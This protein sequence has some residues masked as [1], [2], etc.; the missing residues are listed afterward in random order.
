MIATLLAALALSA[1]PTS[2]PATCATVEMC[3]CENVTLPYVQ[4]C[5]PTSSHPAGFVRISS[6]SEWTRLWA[7]HTATPDKP[8]ALTRHAAPKIDF[9]QCIV[10]AY[11][12]GPSTNRDGEVLSSIITTPDSTTL[13]FEP[14]TFQTSGGLNSDDGGAV[15]TTPFGIWVIPATANPI[16]IEEARRTLK[17]AP[18]THHEVARL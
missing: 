12:R 9:S 5:G 3:Q 4:W 7:A 6:E 8:G 14:S 15:K 16:I 13:R 17:S 18:L 11:F 10:I 2:L 1:L